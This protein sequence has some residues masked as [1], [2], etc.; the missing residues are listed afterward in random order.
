MPMHPAVDDTLAS[1]RHFPGLCSRTLLEFVEWQLGPEGVTDVLAGAGEDRS[2]AAMYDDA[3]W[4]SYDQFRALLEAGARRMGGVDELYRVGDIPT[5]GAGSKPETTALISAFGSPLNM[6]LTMGNGGMFPLIETEVEARGAAALAYKHHL[7][8]GIEPYPELCAYFVGLMPLSVRIFGLRVLDVTEE[9]CRHRGD[10]VC[11]IVVR[12]DETEDLAQQLDHARFQRNLAES[13]LEVFRQTVAEVVSADDLDTV[14]GRIVESAARSNTGG[15]L[16]L[17]VE[18]LRQGTRHYVDGLTPERA[19]LHAARSATGEPGYLVVDVASSRRRYGRIIVPDASGVLEFERPALESYASLAATALDSAFALEDA[20]REAAT[21]EALLQLSESLAEL[22]TAGELAARVVRAMPDVIDSDCA[23]VLLVRDGIARIAAHHGFDASKV[24]TLEEL[25]FVVDTHGFD[26]VIVHT[27]GDSEPIADSL[28]RMME[29]EAFAASP[30]SV[31]DTLIGY[32][33]VGVHDRP[34]RLLDDPHLAERFGGLAGQAAVALRNGRLLDQI[35]HQSLHDSLTD[36]PNRALIL[37][38]AEQMIARAR[39]H[40]QIAAVLFIDLDG[41]KEINDRLGHGAGDELLELVAARLRTTVR[42]SDTVG[43]LGGDEFVVLVEDAALDAGV[44]VVA[45]RLLDVLSEPFTLPGRERP[46]SVGASIGI[47]TGDRGEAADLLRDADIALYSAKAA[48]KGCYRVFAPEMHHEVRNR[49]EL[50]EGL[51]TALENEELFL[52]YQPIFDLVAE[53]TTGVEALLRWNHPERG[54]IGPDDF[55]PLLE[56][57]GQIIEVGRWVLHESC[58]QTAEW[59]AAGH[60]IDVSVNVSVRQIERPE[61]VA[62]VADALI[63]SGLDP[64]SLIIELTETAIMRD[65]EA[66]LVVLQGLKMLGAR[67]AIDDFGTGYSSLA[68]LRQFPVDALKI[69]RSFIAGVADSPAA[70]EL[71]HTLVRL[72]KALDLETLAEGIE[73]REQLERLQLEGCDSGQGFLFARPLPA[74]EMHEFLERQ[75][76][77]QGTP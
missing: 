62:D 75:P 49:A 6:A 40:R 13:R 23:A 17:E 31:E 28:L 55:I 50:A 26:E 42:D 35:R 4:H 45:E 70:W 1:G 43:R 59:H 58:R 73:H 69:D 34:E 29:L 65:A 36:L 71:I 30:I 24:Q 5:V 9:T 68:Y 11:T 27:V 56:E 41:F 8:E 53:A 12:W 33:V 25:E 14:L 7:L 51:S 44:E 37:D 67:I 16:M 2:V 48:G 39:R 63:A 19:A 77:M 76:V 21:S 3:T 54:L 64:S 38:R 61:F 18:T 60:R 10:D 57:S 72:G 20:R 47:A 52:V 74:S 32:L 15:G 22:T 66:T 46:L